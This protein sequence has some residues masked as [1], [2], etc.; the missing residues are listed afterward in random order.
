[1]G[2]S[3][4]MTVQEVAK[5]L[6]LKPLAIYRKVQKNEIPFLKAGRSIRFQ[7]EKIDEWLKWGKL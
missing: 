1:M 6:R 2:E 7:K 4:F 3:Q 5:Y